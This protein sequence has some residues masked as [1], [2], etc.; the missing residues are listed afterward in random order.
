MSIEPNKEK[1]PEF[2]TLRVAEGLG[3]DVGRGIARLDPKD[4]AQ[5][6]VSVGEIV[7]IRGERV[8]VAKAMPAYADARGKTQLQIDGITRANAAA[9]IDQRVK[10]EKVVTTPAS[11]ITLRTAGKRIEEGDEKHFGRLLEGLPVVTGDKLRVNLIGSRSQDFEVIAV[12]PKDSAVVIQANTQVLFDKP[13]PSKKTEGAGAASTG[14]QG[15]VAYEDIG[16]LHKEVRRVREMI[17]LPLRY[18][19]LFE[20]LGID[21]PKGLLLHGPPGTGKTLLARAVAQETE[22]AFISVSG[23]EIIHKFYGESEAKLRSIFEQ[24]KKMS[25]CI[26]FLDEIDAIAPKRENV[27]GEVEKRVVAQLLALMDG[28]ESRGQIIVIGATNLPNLID[29]ALRRPGRFDREI[30]IGIPDAGARREILEIHTR[31]M[32]LAADVDIERIAATTHGFV[33]ADLESLCREAAMTVLRRVIPELDLAKQEVSYEI[34]SGLTVSMD[35]F[36]AA[37]ADIEPSAIREVCVELPDVAWEDV[38][39]LDAAKRELRESIELPQKYP[40]LLKRARV[41]PPKGILLYGPPGTGKTMLAKAVA[42]QSG[43]NFISI[44]GP[45]LVSRYVGDS[46]KGV[47]EAFRK[48][49]QAAPCVLF[50]DE[51]DAIASARGAGGGDSGV[52]ER[53]LS[54]LL[55]EMDGIEELRGVVVVAATNRKDM[56]D[57][58]LLRPGRFD[59]HLEIPVPDEAS[60]AKIF[61]IHLRG[62]AIASE[63]TAA[64]LAKLTAGFGGAHI[65]AVCRRAGLFLVR[66]AIDAHG[67]GAN[68]VQLE[69]GMEM[70]RKAIDEIRRTMRPE[71]LRGR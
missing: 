66:E 70:M 40:D 34:L 13:A 14:S 37:R 45:A 10:I 62:V 1:L 19:Q 6:G 4:M 15:R 48:A 64:E 69:L 25:P 11:K 38:G 54:Q 36:A 22:A 2:I 56:L 41:R 9:T 46:E 49:R 60:R 58:A 55:T 51:I 24:A 17:E 31:G 7:R 50:F 42:A 43:V 39:G 12:L 23:P 57:P 20:R 52:T 28:L 5:L 16:G 67:D 65:E 26:I 3:K 30:E 18:P 27:Q 61:A 21:P 32:P 35:D 33:G 29:P 59:L 63:V 68:T 8:T 71:D 44:K 53:V 47:R